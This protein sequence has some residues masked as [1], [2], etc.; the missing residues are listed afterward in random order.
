M[1]KNSRVLLLLIVTTTIL[2][3]IYLGT[4]HFEEVPLSESH[5]TEDV[6]VYVMLKE[7]NA[8]FETAIF[9]INVG[10]A[11][12][13]ETNVP[14]LAYSGKPGRVHLRV[15]GE[16]VNWNGVRFDVT[17]DFSL[18]TEG[19]KSYLVALTLVHKPGV[20]VIKPDS[21]LS[22]IIGEDIP[23]TLLLDDKFF[24]NRA[25]AKAN[26]TEELK[27]NRELREKYLGL[28]E[29]TKNLSYLLAY[30]D[31]SYHL[32]MISMLGKAGK[33]TDT[34]L[35]TYVLD[36]IATDYYYSRF[37]KPGK[38]DLI[39]VFSNE[40]P[41]Y[42]AIK[43][44]DGPIKSH[45]PFIY[46]RGR[47]FNL[48]PVSA[49]HWAHVYFE[50]DRPNVAVEILQELQDFIEHGKYQTTEYAIFPVYFHFQNASI[51]W[52]SGYAQG[53]GAGLYALAYNITGNES[54]LQT[55]K[56]LL[57]S[58]E[59]PLER[60]GF[61]LQTPYGPW[62][63]EYNYYPEQLVLNGH[64]ISLQGLYYYWKVTGDQRAYKHFIEGAL[65]V[66]RA[67]PFFDT[68]NWSRY[69]SIYNSSSIFYHRLHVRLLVWLYAKTGEEEFIEYAKRWNGYLEEKG[70]KK[71]DI[72]AL[73][74]Q[75]R[76][77]P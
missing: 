71:E 5:E 36:I 41:Y 47:G 12:I 15:G 1:R 18:E 9:K 28:W 40:C 11:R 2:G 16:V 17:G 8:V 54:Y 4:S 46:Y 45:M 73:L 52:V 6:R 56:L 34:A 26:A 65:S 19:G 30:R 7:E 53:L 31:L 21:R 58:F 69:A 24:V 13:N 67:L 66:K 44:T 50:K 77:T 42:G 55:A 57:N 76:K 23:D 33:L 39:L 74:Q 25:M 3:I 62:Y 59:L 14:A 43:V 10:K 68:G 37:T 38:K 27:I 75:M 60:N 70:L 29:Q 32:K 64:I 61:V 22:G 48:Y 20:F 72:E 35:K 49:L 63:L 51:P